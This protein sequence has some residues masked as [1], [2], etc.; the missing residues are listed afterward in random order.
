MRSG[1]VALEVFEKNFRHPIS[2]QGGNGIPNLLGNLDLSSQENKAIRK[3]LEAGSFSMS[4][5]SVL[6]RMKIPTLFRLEEF[7]PYGKRGP[8]SPQTS[9]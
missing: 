9:E 7:G 5:G 8:I 4:N 3:R 6:I 1:K 2:Q